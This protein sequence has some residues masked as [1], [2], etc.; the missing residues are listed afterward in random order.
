MFA[1]LV[2]KN[3]CCIQICALSVMWGN[4]RSSALTHAQD[5]LFC[6]ILCSAAVSLLPSLFPHSLWVSPV[7]VTVLHICKLFHWMYRQFQMHDISAHVISLAFLLSCR[8]MFCFC[9]PIVCA[10][11]FRCTDGS[12]D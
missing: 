2:F 4:K 9:T 11:T 10:Q 3:V 6:R 7:R 1:H 12:E 8:R 5:H